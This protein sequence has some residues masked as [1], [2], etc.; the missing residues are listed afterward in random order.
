MEG[1]RFASWITDRSRCIYP[2]SGAEGW[3]IIFAEFSPDLGFS[4]ALPPPGPNLSSSRWFVV[5]WPRIGVLENA[6]VAVNQKGRG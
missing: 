6:E 5:G 2:P 3:V 1:R 4:S